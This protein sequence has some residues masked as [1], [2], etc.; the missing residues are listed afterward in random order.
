MRLLAE[1]FGGLAIGIFC[2]IYFHEYGWKRG[3]AKGY[4]MG[5]QRGFEEGHQKGLKEGF[6]AGKMNADNF[7]IHA[8]QDVDQVRQKMRKEGWP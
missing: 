3:S 7:W 2:A 8:E 4:E 6:E 5:Y 1:I